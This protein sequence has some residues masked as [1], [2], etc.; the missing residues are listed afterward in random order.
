MLESCLYVNFFVKDEILKYSK[1][2]NVSA[3]KFAKY[4]INLAC[5]YEVNV[6]IKGQ[7]VSY[8]KT[9]N[10]ESCEMLRYRLSDAEHKYF[11]SERNRLETSISKLLLIGFLL[12]FG[13]LLKEKI[14]CGKIRDS[15]T[16]FFQTY[17]FVL[18]KFKENIQKHKT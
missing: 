14:I 4:L 9:F 13:Y 11:C 5:S 6:E 8:Q 17:Y 3:C 12:F 18:L 7:L 10:N 2:E 15:Y 1:D 16:T